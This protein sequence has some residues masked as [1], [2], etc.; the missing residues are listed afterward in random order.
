MLAL[1]TVCFQKYFLIKTNTEEQLQNKQS[2]NTLVFT[3]SLLLLRSSGGNNRSCRSGGRS[4][5]MRSRKTTGDRLE[6]KVNIL[7]CLG[8][9]MK[10]KRATK[11]TETS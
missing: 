5:S 3:T 4:G 10:R 7:L 9:D 8:L 11:H 6:H 1:S 2:T